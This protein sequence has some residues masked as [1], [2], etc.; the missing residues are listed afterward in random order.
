MTEERSPMK[1]LVSV[2]TTI[3]IIFTIVVGAFMVANFR[4]VVRMVEVGL[5]VKTQSLKPVD[6]NLL[7]EGAVRG[8]VDSLEDPYSSFMT[9]N[10]FLEMQRYIQGSIG[11]IG[12]YVGIKDNT[13]VVQAPI[14]GTPAAKAGILSEDIIVKINDTF[15]ADLKYDEAV[16][17]MRGDPG[18]QVKISIMR[19]GA[20]K[21]L[22]FTLTRE[23]IDLPTV[24]SEVLKDHPDIGYLRLRMFASNSDEALAQELKKL[25]DQSI[26][27]LILDL[28]DNPG[29]DLESAVNIA[30]NFVP[31]G[32]VVFT[33]DRGGVTHTYE[34]QEEPSFKAPV[35]ILINGG[36]ASASEVL[37]GA[38]KDT[39]VGTLVG[40]K[41]FGK[42]IVQAIFPLG[43]GDGLKLTTSKY[44]T[45][46]KVDIHEKGIEPD[47]AIAP[48]ANQTED[49]QLKKALEVL[50]TKIK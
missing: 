4:N 36:S 40:E 39:K 20:N 18:T 28:R 7:L 31:K 34:S 26:K 42:G 22:E 33:V 37:A 9:K 12:I 8:M 38:M 47:V 11:G 48:N 13:I 24:S 25:Q 45:P 6:S 35:V 30:K 29:G 14:E 23:I 49:L 17:M 41:T 43:G 27:G 10:E 16:T 50:L 15:T 21:L 3:C 5:L 44:L 2:L 46:N 32:P 19:Q 1:R